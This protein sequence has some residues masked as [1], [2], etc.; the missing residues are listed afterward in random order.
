MPYTVSRFGCSYNREYMHDLC[1]V[2]AIEN[3][4]N[5]QE[6]VKKNKIV[7]RKKQIIHVIIMI[8][9]T[10]PYSFKVQHDYLR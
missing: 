5:P 8:K 7:Y 2:T 4:N 6:N 1:Y 9:F 3:K 10:I